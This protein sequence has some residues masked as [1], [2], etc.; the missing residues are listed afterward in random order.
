ML[1]KKALLTLCGGSKKGSAPP[2]SNA[3]TICFRIELLG[4][5]KAA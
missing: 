3:F 5:P 4:L 1:Q 2:K